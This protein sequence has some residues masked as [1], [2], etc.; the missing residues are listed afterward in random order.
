MKITNVRTYRVN[1]P[2]RPGWSRHWIFVEVQTDEGISGLGDATNWPMGEVVDAAVQR[3]AQ[4]IIGEDP[5][6]IEYLWQKM[7]RLTNYI[8]IAGAVVTAISGIDIAL[9][10]LL[11]KRLNTPVYQLLGGRCRDE[12]PIYANYWNHDLAPTPEAYAQR[13]AEIVALGYKGLKFMP[14]LDLGWIGPLDRTIR[15]GQLAQ[16]VRLVAAVRDA[17]GPE[18]EIYIEAGG[19]LSPYS[20]TPFAEALAPYRISYI[21]EP[22]PP[23]NVEAL[24]ELAHKSPIPI[25]AGERMYTHYGVRRFLELNA[26]AM[27]Q[28]DIVRTGGLTAA[29]K[30]AAMA[31]AYYVPVSPHNPNS[32]ISTLASVHFALSTPNFHSL[33]YLVYDSPL[34]E[35]LVTPVLQPAHGALPIPSGSGLCADI[36]WELL[37]KIGES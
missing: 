8:G 23:E 3:V 32:P 27:L 26:V 20:F 18:I 31:D 4:E 34:R 28:P 22:L 24:A 13:A 6:N 15:P 35:S 21:E 12:V 10:D 5:A 29:K 17:V 14:F 7:Y 25:A 16:A 11:G 1:A 37:Q 2:P 33:E 9:W 36:N 19:K 30:I